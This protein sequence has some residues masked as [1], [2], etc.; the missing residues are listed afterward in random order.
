MADITQLGRI[1]KRVRAISE[2]TLDEVPVLPDWFVRQ[3]NLSAYND[4]WQEW[5][6]KAQSAVR[7]ALS[8]TKELNNLVL[9]GTGSPEG[10]IAS[11]PGKIYLNLSGG[12]GQTLYVKET[13]SDVDGW[14]S[15]TGGSSS[16]Q[17]ILSGE[18]SPENVRVG[19]FLGQP[20][21]DVTNGNFYV[22]TG[23]AG[24][25]TGWTLVTTS[26]SS[27]TTYILSGAGSP[28]GSTTGQFQGQPYT[29]VSTGGL[30]TFIGTPG[31]TNGW[32]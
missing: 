25:K 11:T 18:G 12:A 26:S 30:Y 24:N 31:S 5:R 27:I 29:D 2:F 13:G 20:Y 23:V 21:T 19:S 6:Q 14:V 10:R 22:F 28:E 8:A 7:D 9:F 4:A 1:A 15:V 17:D 16:S 3:F 32:V